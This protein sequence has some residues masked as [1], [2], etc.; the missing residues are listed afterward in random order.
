LDE[1][2]EEQQDLRDKQFKLPCPTIDAWAA[3][4]F[5]KGEYGGIALFRQ[6]P[7]L[8]IESSTELLDDIQGQIDEQRDNE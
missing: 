5:E 7:G 4:E 6:M 3:R 2:A 1:I 8:L